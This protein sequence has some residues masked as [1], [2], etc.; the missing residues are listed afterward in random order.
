MPVYT[1]YCNTC[2]ISDDHFGSFEDLMACRP[3]CDRCGSDMARHIGVFAKTAGKWGDSLGYFDRGL[4][5]YISSPDQRERIM[6]ERGLV[7]VSKAQLD[8]VQHREY[9]E[10]I[11]HQQQ[12]SLFQDTMKATNNNITQSIDKTFNLTENL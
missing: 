2:K 7:E 1:Y 8:E 9:T 12:V 6:E 5:Q 11:Q 4:G 3:K 10:H